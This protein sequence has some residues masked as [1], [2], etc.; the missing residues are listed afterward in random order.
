MTKQRFIKLLMSHGEPRN[1]ARTMALSY[2][3]RGI[4]YTKAYHDYLF[5]NACKQFATLG[6]ACKVIG[7]NIA[8][9]ACLF[10]KFV[11][12]VGNG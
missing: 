4:P 3:S 6:A 12:V 7:D 11:E 1:R 9:M 8:I 5:K 2:N 10:K